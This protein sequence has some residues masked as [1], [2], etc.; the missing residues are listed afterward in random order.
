[1]AK[2]RKV[3]SNLFVFALINRCSGY[4]DAKAGTVTYL[5]IHDTTIGGMNLTVRFN[6]IN[7]NYVSLF[8]QT[9]SSA[10]QKRGGEAEVDAT[11]ARV[12]PGGGTVIKKASTGMDMYYFVAFMIQAK[13]GLNSCTLTYGVEDDGKNIV[14]YAY[15]TTTTGHNCETMADAKDIDHGIR[16]CVH[17]LNKHGA[18]SGCCT[19]YHGGTWTGHLQ[20]TADPAKWPATYADC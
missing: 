15:R 6:V 8:N 9:E 16:D 18:G 4:Y 5:P 3:F 2:I 14:G 19:L 13:S 20:L 11:I 17:H 12:T 10:K 7:E 1:M